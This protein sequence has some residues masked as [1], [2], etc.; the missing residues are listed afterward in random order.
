MRI[1]RK[2]FVPY[3]LELGFHNNT[4]LKT[5]I[6]DRIGPETEGWFRNA[7]KNIQGNC[8][9]KKGVHF[10][11]V[12]K[13]AMA[14]FYQAIF[15]RKPYTYKDSYW[16]LSAVKGFFDACNLTPYTTIDELVST[17]Y[18]L[19]DKALFRECYLI[20]QTAYFFNSDN[21]GSH[22]YLTYM[23]E[24][25][26]NGVKLPIEEYNHD[27][28]H[29]KRSYERID[30]ERKKGTYK[31]KGIIEYYYTEQWY[32]SNLLLI[33]TELGLSKKNFRASYKK[34]REFNITVLTPRILRWETPFVLTHIDISSAYPSFLDAIVGSNIAPTIYERVAK[35]K[36]ISRSEAKV[37]FLKIIN[38]GKY[39]HWRKEVAIQDLIEWGY[40]E[41]QAEHVT[42]FTHDPEKSF[43][44][45][46]SQIEEQAI[47]KFA[48]VNAVERYVRLHDALLYIDSKKPNT[49][50]KLQENT[51]R[52]ESETPKKPN[53]NHI[54]G[55]SK[56]RLPTAYV[57]SLPPLKELRR[58]TDPV[59]NNLKGSAEGFSFY[60]SK[61]KYKSA[62]FDL[63][64][65]FDKHSFLEECR[66]MFNTIYYL[67]DRKANK[68]EIELIVRHIRSKSNIC[69]QHR[70]M[71]Q[72]LRKINSESVKQAETK[73][74][75]WSFYEKRNFR[76]KIDFLN[77]FNSAKKKVNQIEA[78]KYV[79]QRFIE[80]LEEGEKGWIEFGLPRSEGTKEARAMASR[81]NYL[82][83]NRKRKP[84][85]HFCNC[86]P[87]YVF[88]YKEPCSYKLEVRN[89][90]RTNPTLILKRRMKAHAKDF[91]RLDQLN[92]SGKLAEQYIFILN[93]LINEEETFGLERN[94]EFIQEEKKLIA[95]TLEVQ[96]FREL[97]LIKTDHEISPKEATEEIFDTDLTDSIFNQIDEHQ[98][99]AQG[100]LEEFQTFHKLNPSV[101]LE[102]T[103]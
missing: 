101:N 36:K 25:E 56:R 84:R 80:A 96:E 64:D 46:M 23:A 22:Q 86:D 74:R 83:T 73:E 81:I 77:A 43:T 26:R 54:F 16:T 47:H 50:F 15:P 57:R 13:L 28:G 41:E 71:Y 85:P 52:F 39:Y 6:Q 3:Y 7:I 4:N 58:R 95:E 94:E 20:I 90:A 14:Y 1:E 97:I 55:M 19:Q 24:Y 5:D 35:A 44:E 45:H 78:I 51:I 27:K 67:N 32:Y 38:S 40:T 88:I 60:H 65:E 76:K 63:N 18:P 48:E 92:Q 30:E 31:N 8:K 68:T 17:C 69:F 37:H 53:F 59:K 93:E 91:Q 89:K 70:S 33:V 98:A 66:A 82:R 103:G 99:N 72:I 21:F 2:R 49:E 62:V 75:D 11:E 100:M 61:Y 12:V 102:S 29:L 9:E 87:L 34:S 79:K 42:L 10:S